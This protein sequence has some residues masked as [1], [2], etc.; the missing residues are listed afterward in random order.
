MRASAPNPEGRGVPSRLRVSL[1]WALGILVLYLAR[2]T[3]RSLALGL[4]LVA[5][6]E[7]IRLWASG[8]IEKTLVLATGGPY[9]HSRNPL[10]VGSVLLALGLAIAAASLWVA[11]AVVLYF[12]AFYPSVMREEADFLR[13]KFP[14]DYAGW[15]AE[16]P[17]FL[18]RLS[19]GGPRTSRFSWPRVRANK[20]WR[21]AVALP[22]V[23]GLLWARGF[24]PGG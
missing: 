8:H 19:P 22:A 11:A 6:G 3:P 20:E 1:G 23:A 21:T 9:A 5:L 16:V 17:M 7:I 18:P 12:T 14:Q 13:R 2:P 4:P 10:Y 15:E 24:I